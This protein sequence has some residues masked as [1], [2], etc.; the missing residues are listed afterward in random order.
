MYE[1]W[2]SLQ[3]RVPPYSNQITVIRITMN[4]HVEGKE[5]RRDLLTNDATEDSVTES[6]RMLLNIAIR[7]KK[8][9]KYPH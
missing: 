9:H 4:E 8:K 3:S 7:M 6:A 5:W 1:F 2:T